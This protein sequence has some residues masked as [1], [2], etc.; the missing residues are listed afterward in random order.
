M[1]LSY[2][3]MEEMQA[4]LAAAKSRFVELKTYVETGRVEALASVQ[5]LDTEI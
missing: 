2:P 4:L 1:A 3:V 5:N